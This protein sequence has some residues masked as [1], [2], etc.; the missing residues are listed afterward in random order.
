MPSASPQRAAARR[1]TFTPVDQTKF[2]APEGNCLMACVASITGIPLEALDDLYTAEAR[3]EGSHW[4][5]VFTSALNRHGWHAVYLLAEDGV[6]P[7]GYAVG[8]GVSPRGL[9]HAVVVQDGAIVHDP[10]PSRAGVEQVEAFY[11]LFPIL[12]AT[13]RAA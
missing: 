13:E 9:R 10:H 11:A 2:G 3:A 5:D 4:W 8:S 6:I 1:E 12:T 7:R